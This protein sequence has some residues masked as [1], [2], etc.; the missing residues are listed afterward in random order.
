MHDRPIWDALTTRQ[1]YLAVGDEKVKRYPADIAPFIAAR[2]GDP[3][4]R[5]AMADW[6]TAG[7]LLYLID[8]DEVPT[9]GWEVEKSSAVLQMVYRGKRGV[10]GADGEYSVLGP[11]DVPE[12]LGLT[13][14]AFP[15][16]FRARTVELG[17]YVGVRVD[18][19]LVAMAGMRM[20]PGDFREVSGVCTHPDHR[21]RGYARRLIAATV[22]EILDQGHTPFLHVDAAN[23][24]ARTAYEA[25]GFEV[26]AEL[27]FVGL[28]R[29]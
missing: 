28:R 20:F 9:A 14:L 3:A 8:G 18:G 4:A 27:P 22:A 24:G 26:R 1:A 29:V 17:T 21:G 13:A 25:I 23:H 11:D 2:G 5:A 15:G 6:A 16:Y 12:M 19:R 10:D 7:E